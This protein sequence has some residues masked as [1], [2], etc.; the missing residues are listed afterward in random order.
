MQTFTVTS[1]N[2]CGLSVIG[3]EIVYIQAEGLV[4]FA[5]DSAAFTEYATPADAA[6]AAL[7][8]NPS[9]DL[10][11]IY[12]P[13]VLTQVNVSES[14]V[15]ASYGDSVTFDCEYSCDDATA[16]VTYQWSGPDGNPIAGATS[17]S[18][19]LTDALSFSAGTYT[20][21]VTASNP[22]GQSGSASGSFALEVSEPHAQFYLTRTA[23]N[24]TDGF[25]NASTGFDQDLASIYLVDDALD[26]VYDAAGD[27]FKTTGGQLG[28]GAQTFEFR[29]SGAFVKSFTLPVGNGTYTFTF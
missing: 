8:I 2:T 26:V 17:S 29:I 28:T 7:A 19:T 5:P 27:G 6:A 13:L 14:E 25:F 23:T 18:Y 21:A 9:Y 11:N 20:C 16:T 10:N 15:S 12:G 3:T 4:T 22:D 1:P 24:I